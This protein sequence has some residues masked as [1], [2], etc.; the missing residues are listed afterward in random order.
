MRRMMILVLA[1]A[2]GCD[3][4]TDPQQ[5]AT[6]EN[7]AIAAGSPV[8]PAVAP[9]TPPVGT[10]GTPG[11][12]P[13]DRTPL[14]EPK[15]PID[16]KSAEGAGQVVQLYAALIGEGKFAEAERAWPKGIDH[17]PLAPATLA[18]HREI[19]GEVGKPYDQEGAM[20]S[21]FVK[22]PFRLYGTARDGTPFNLVGPLTL[23]RVSE[24]DGSTAA[25][26]RWHL[27]GAELVSRP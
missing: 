8:K 16:P 20:G 13:D 3:R 9:V 17:G 11:G 4:S 19:H 14:I 23:R 27:V 2:G 24:V 26:R 6:P 18:T 10:P 5:Q 7:A 21:S 25:Q 22:V 1:L 15:G 12:L